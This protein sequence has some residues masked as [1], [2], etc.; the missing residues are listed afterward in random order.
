MIK[1]SRAYYFFCMWLAV[2]SATA[3]LFHSVDVFLIAGVGVALEWM[4]I[5]VFLMSLPAL[6]IFANEKMNLLVKTLLGIVAAFAVAVAGKYFVQFVFRIPPSL[7]LKIQ[8]LLIVGGLLSFVMNI[9]YLLFFARFRYYYH[10]LENENR[11][12]TP[13]SF[14]SWLREENIEQSAKKLKGS[15]AL[16]SNIFI[17]LLIIAFFTI[18]RNEHANVLYSIFIVLFAFSALGMYFILKQFDSILNWKLQTM[19]VTDKLIEN[20][21]KLLRLIAIPLIVI[22]LAIPWYFRLIDISNLSEA[23]NNRLAGVTIDIG[24]GPDRDVTPDQFSTNATYATNESTVVITEQSERFTRQTNTTRWSIIPY[25]KYVLYAAIGI[26]VLFFVF[27]IIGAALNRKLRYNRKSKFAQMFINVY[28]AMRGLIDGLGL[29]FALIGRFFAALFGFHKFRG[30]V[31]D[32]ELAQPVAAQL[33]MLFGDDQQ[34][35]DDKKDEIRTIVRDFVKMIEVTGRFVTPYRFYYGPLEY[36]DLVIAR[37][38]ELKEVLQITVRTFNE[39]R[40]SLHI[41]SDV[42]IGNF[43]GAVKYVIDHITEIGVNEQD[44]TQKGT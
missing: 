2:S 14:A 18:V 15:A 11:F 33:F 36:I 37:V 39:S 41:L 30:K 4:K 31:D 35:S 8:S 16:F 32:K 21:N 34:M 22:P 25:L 6:F 43:Q 26:F 28:R 40:Y 10:Y 17:V 23:I 3:M 7:L 27:G 19:E 12:T 24:T 29:F 20:W 42:K 9:F 1:Q 13:E 44:G 5:A 38:P